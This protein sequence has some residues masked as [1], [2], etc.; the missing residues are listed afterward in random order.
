MTRTPRAAEYSRSYADAALLLQHRVLNE[1][2]DDL[3]L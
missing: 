2:E 1:S 3:G